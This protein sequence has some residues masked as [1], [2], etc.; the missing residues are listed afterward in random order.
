MYRA[1]LRFPC[2]KSSLASAANRARLSISSLDEVQLPVG[3]EQLRR[4]GTRTSAVAAML[5]DDIR[6]SSLTLLYGR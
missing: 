6:K 4:R 1:W 5:V 3:Y 2:G